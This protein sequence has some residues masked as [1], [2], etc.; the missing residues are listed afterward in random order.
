MATSVQSYG[1]SLAS[2]TS[3][4]PT[5]S[6]DGAPRKVAAVCFRRG[7]RGIEFLLVRTDSGK[8][9]F[10]KGSI[11][12]GLTEAGSAQLE[13]FEEAGATGW[14]EDQH[15]ESYLHVK[16][17]RE[18]LVLAFLMEVWSTGRPLETHRVPVW[19]TPE[20]AKKRLARLR[21]AKYGRELWRVVDRAVIRISTIN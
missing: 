3:L 4:T 12:Q 21:P 7:S 15:F 6:P 18:M 8:W 13:A 2:R 11:E 19:C 10:P 20:E 9:T 14:V 5:F 1:K 17:D 16:R